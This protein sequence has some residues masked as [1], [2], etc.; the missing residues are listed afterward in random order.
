MAGATPRPPGSAGNGP[1]LGRLMLLRARFGKQAAFH[2]TF[3]SRDAWN[4]ADTGVNGISIWRH[5]PH[6]RHIPTRVE[7]TPRLAAGG[8][9]FIRSKFFWRICQSFR[10]ATLLWYA[11]LISASSAFLVGLL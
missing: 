5:M 8:V 3:F 4:R 1:A 2:S 6:L 9:H 10:P 11:L 7:N